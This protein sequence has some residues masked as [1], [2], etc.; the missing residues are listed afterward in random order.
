MSQVPVAP[1]FDYDAMSN[2]INTSGGKSPGMISRGEFGPIGLQRV[3]GR[4]HRMLFLERPDP[5]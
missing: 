2:W 1:T 3:I 5:A 4:G